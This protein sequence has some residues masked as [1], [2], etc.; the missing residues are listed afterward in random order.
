MDSQTTTE[1]RVHQFVLETFPLA[2]SKSVAPDT[3]LVNTGIV[4][5]MGILEQ[6]MFIETEFSVV[7]SDEDVV[8]DNF[9][10]INSI[11][12][13]INSKLNA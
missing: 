1:S 7:L 3:S 6:V 8:A 4:D 9:D 5:S 13:F 12:E 10:S 11:A 2:R